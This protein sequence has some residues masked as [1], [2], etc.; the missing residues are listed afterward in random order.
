MKLNKWLFYL[1]LCIGSIGYAQKTNDKIP[2][3]AVISSIEQQFNVKFSYA[4]EDVA[5]IA[6]EKPAATLTLQET[7]DYLN[8][9]VLLNFKALDNRYV[10][11]SVLN[12]TISVCGTVFSEEL[13]T[14]LV[15]AT[16]LVGNSVAIT[17]K[18]GFFTI[19]NVPITATIS[20]SYL[21][22]EG[23][24]FTA[25]QLF[26]TSSSCKTLF[27]KTSN[28]ELNQV[29]INVYLTP[30]LQKYLDGS[31][32]LN[33]KKFGILPGLIEPDVLQ[34]IQVLPGVESTNESIANINVRGGTNDQNL[35]I[36]DNIKMYHSGHFFGLIS[37]YN[38]NLTN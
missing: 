35:M 29:L 13:K 30:G 32:V 20:I 23:K 22:Y 3:A 8:S 14:P 38:P 1:L 4:V 2:L 12:K 34:S 33:T 25:N 11:V 7:M 24:Q 28:E 18:N 6:V 31:T 10:T 37:A 19:P 9:K 26:S 17:N 16:V 5:G 36:W 15:G 21:G 27:L